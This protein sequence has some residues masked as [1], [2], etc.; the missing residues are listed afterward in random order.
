MLTNRELVGDVGKDR[1]GWCP[2]RLREARE[3]HGLTLEAA[4]EQLRDTA[5]RAGLTAP[6]ANFQ[7]LWQ[8]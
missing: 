3:A 2:E 5:R 8:Q 1:S 4:G 6:A 7:T